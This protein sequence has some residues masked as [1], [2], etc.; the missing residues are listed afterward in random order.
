MTLE[1]AAV[2][3]FVWGATS[4]LIFLGVSM[5]EIGFKKDLANMMF[6]GITILIGISIV[7][8]LIFI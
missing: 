5:V 7:L 8:A 2:G 6:V 4:C 3:I 1:G